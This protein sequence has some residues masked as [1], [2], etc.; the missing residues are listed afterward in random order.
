MTLPRHHGCVADLEGTPSEEEPDPQAVE[1]NITAFIELADGLEGP[2]VQSL[3]NQVAETMSAAWRT[4]EGQT[5]GLPQNKL[6][7]VMLF[8]GRAAAQTSANEARHWYLHAA[9]TIVSGLVGAPNP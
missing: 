8:L 6:V 5:A 1:R 3:A 9:S 7:A 4:I 2:S